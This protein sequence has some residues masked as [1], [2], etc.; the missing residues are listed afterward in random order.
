MAKVFRTNEYYVNKAEKIK[1]ES[2]EVLEKV[3]KGELNIP[4]ATKLLSATPREDWS[5]SELERKKKVEDG[6]A[7]L[8]NEQTD[9]NLIAWAGADRC[10]RID[11]RSWFANPYINQE[12]GSRDEVC[13]LYQETYL[14]NKK[15]HIKLPEEAQRESIDLSMLPESGATVNHCCGC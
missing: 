14:P 5:D 10:L 11:S 9:L 12:D 2:P 4:Q 15:I 13:D 6:Q 8:A 7:V 3:K 1:R